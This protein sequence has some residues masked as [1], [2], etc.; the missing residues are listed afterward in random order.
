[1]T[2]NGLSVR[3]FEIYCIVF[4]VARILHTIFYL[5]SIQPWR[6]VAYTIGVIVTIALAIQLLIKVVFA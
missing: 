6:T 4:T 5:N 2:A 3:A 1:V